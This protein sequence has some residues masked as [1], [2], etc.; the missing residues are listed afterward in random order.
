MLLV[1]DATVILTAFL[2]AY[3]I[4]FQTELQN[5]FSTKEQLDLEAYFMSAY[6]RAAIIFTVLWLAMMARDGLYSHRLISASSPSA[7]VQQILWSGL[8][9]LAILMA[10]SFLFRGFLLSRFVY[11]ISFGLSAI[12]IIASRELGRRLTQKVLK[13]GVPARRTLVIGTAP[14]AIQ[15]AST[16]ETKS[17]GFQE[18]VGFLEFPDER[19]SNPENTPGCKIVGDVNEIDVVRSKIEFDRVI[20]SATDFVG[21]K[22]QDRSP[23]LLRVLNY[24]EAYG[25]PLY[26]ISFSTDV[27]VLR[28]EMGSYHGIPLL[29][30]RD[31]T[32][33]PVY[34]VVKRFLDILLSLVVLILGAP[35]WIAIAISIKRGSKGPVLYVQERIGM[36][37]K[38][39]KM[40]KF[41]SMIEGADDQLAELVDFSS[42]SEPVFNL[43]KDPRVTK[44]GS[45]L[46]RTS[47]DEIPQ[48]INVLKGEMSVVGPRPERTE[49][50]QLYNDY[51][52]RRLKAKPG[53]TGYQ[54]VMSRGDPSLSR[55]IEFDLYYLKRQSIWFDLA[56]LFKTII[57]VIRGDGMK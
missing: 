49:L 10:I 45:F 17:N 29:L 25:I 44:I 6:I 3:M 54:Q 30:L 20:V 36:N 7:E 47:L 11:G 33:H 55:R 1:L 46:R 22:E 43:R 23:L 27:M 18:V 32:R 4:R 13:L 8:Q 21:P 35:L 48:F 57:V 38:P 9:S 5:Y 39:F 56:V 14:L 16:L 40:L 28:S 19:C 26:L 2:I 51:Q 37:G 24:C 34:M 15:F 42:M 31:S 41:R 52:W 53:I 12:G 50:V